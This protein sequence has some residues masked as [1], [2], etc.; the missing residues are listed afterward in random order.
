M[1][2]QYSLQTDEANMVH[3]P[4]HGWENVKP[5]W[6][7]QLEAM[8]RYLKQDGVRTALAASL[9]DV[10]DTLTAERKMR[11]VYAELNVRVVQAFELTAFKNKHLNSVE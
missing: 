11:L 10:T 3:R 8:L 5:V 7:E 6:L 1:I 4:N 9:S 2:K